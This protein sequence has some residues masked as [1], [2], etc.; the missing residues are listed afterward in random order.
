VFDVRAKVIQYVRSFLD[1][2]HFLEVETPMMN[3]IAGG[4]TAKPFITHHNDLDLDMFMRIAPELYLKQLVIGGLERVY[5]IGRQFRNEGIDLTH[6][7]EFTT[8]EFYMAYADYHD[9]LEMTE[10]M[11]SGMVKEITGGYIVPYA[12]EEGC[13]PVLIDFSPPWR[14]ISMIEGLEEAMGCK[15]PPL[16]SPDITK[17]LEGLCTNFQVECRPPRTVARLID[18]LVGHFLEDNIINP[19]FITEHP[20]LMSPLAKTHRSKPGLTERFELFVCKREVCN[21]YTEL[22]HP[23]VQR[24]R[25]E[26]QAK[27]ATQGDDEAQVSHILQSL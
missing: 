7:P 14:R 12:A 11:I 20:E 8:C 18:K 4:A 9:L 16:D 17:F 15:F 19:T 3:V 1:T 21:A 10:Q 22:N 6:N 27:Q 13:E 26:E 24:S 23:I 2:R 5:E 25:F